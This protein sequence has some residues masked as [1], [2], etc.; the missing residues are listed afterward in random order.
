[1]SGS[2]RRTGGASSIG[3]GRRT[4]IPRRVRPPR[5]RLLADKRRP[6]RRRR[7]TRRAGRRPRHDEWSSGARSRV[8]EAARSR[9]R[10]RDARPARRVR[11]HARP[12]RRR[13][14]L[15]PGGRTRDDTPV[16]LDGAGAREVRER[17]LTATLGASVGREHGDAV[18]ERET[19]ASSPGQKRRPGFEHEI[20]R[21]RVVERV[22]ER[23][24]VVVDDAL[25]RDEVTA[26][27]G[28]MVGQDDRR[29]RSATRPRPPVAVGSMPGRRP[30]RRR[31]PSPVRAR[32]PRQHGAS[33]T[34]SAS[35][36]DLITGA[37]KYARS[38][39]GRVHVRGV[40]RAR[41]IR[42]RCRCRTRRNCD[43]S[44][45]R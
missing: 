1:V 9:G 19:P 28:F 6:G 35:G 14:G 11:L 37:S 24:R 33:R 31:R 4:P 12:G 5:R 27:E 23:D 30:G 13:R 41:G 42:P 44:G 20:A 7:G 15:P 18:G 2:E 10:R 29:W 34:T 36:T 17:P 43:P 38:A 21:D 16:D 3:A 26:W 32:V 39:R 40:V 22:A 8:C 45:R 25:G